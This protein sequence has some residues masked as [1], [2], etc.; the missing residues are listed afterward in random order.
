MAFIKSF[1]AVLF[2]LALIF[3][4]LGFADLLS[5]FRFGL[6]G[7]FRLAFTATT[8]RMGKFQAP[9][10]TLYRKYRWFLPILVIIFL[11]SVP[12][13]I[14]FI[15]FDLMTIIWLL[16]KRSEMVKSLADK[17][18]AFREMLKGA[19][20]KLPVL[21]MDIDDNGRIVID[22][23]VDTTEVLLNDTRFIGDD[24]SMRK[25][26]NKLPTS[27]KIR[28]S[29]GVKVSEDEGV[30]SYEFTTASGVLSKATD[31]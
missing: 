17:R 7:H 31:E 27:T 15:I 8:L 20:D 10:V 14:F 9:F 26:F 25:A 2:P 22:A 18:E 11:V 30:S 4:L 23:F 16:A 6:V 21:D 12:L 1:M 28:I 24:A 3:L 19:E 29:K 13:G 5:G